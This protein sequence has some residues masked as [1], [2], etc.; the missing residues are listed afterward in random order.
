MKIQQQNSPDLKSLSDLIK[1][2]PICM[3]THQDDEGKLVS[4]PMTPIEMTSDGVLWFLTNIQQVHLNQLSVSNVCFTDFTKGSYISISGAGSIS[5]NQARIDELWSPAGR[6]WFPDGPMSED[7]AILKFTPSSAEYWD[8][9]HNRILRTF[10]LIAS[11][12][13][14]KPVGMGDHNKIT[15]LSQ[16]PPKLDLASDSHF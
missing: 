6:P 9:P 14:R 13:A 1:D 3:L 2:I 11:V 12:I 7:I 10:A 15:E 8:G 5:I 16:P 4:K